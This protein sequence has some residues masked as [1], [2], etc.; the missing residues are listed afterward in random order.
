MHACIYPVHRLFVG[1]HHFNAFMKLNNLFASICEQYY[2]REIVIDS[3]S[4]N[5]WVSCVDDFLNLFIY[6]TE[7]LPPENVVILSRSETS[8]SLEWN[9]PSGS[10]MSGFTVT[11]DPNE[12]SGLDPS[13]SAGVY[14]YTR[15]R[16]YFLSYVLMHIV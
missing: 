4:S 15:V 6:S 1:R 3:S 11:V 14:Q 2:L 13:S 16:Q 12:G 7:P 10:V 5:Q 9:A 8:I